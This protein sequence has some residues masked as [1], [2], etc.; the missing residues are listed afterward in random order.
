LHDLIHNRSTTIYGNGLVVRD[1]VHAPDVGSAV[2]QLLTA[3]ATPTI[4][5]VGSG[6]GRSILD[7][8]SICSSVTGRELSVR[9]ERARSFDIEKNVLDISRL[10][11]LIDFS[12]TEP[13]SAIR[14]IWGSMAGGTETVAHRNLRRLGG[15]H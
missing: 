2:L 12:P 5:N 13:E 4:L 9:F 6:R 1:Y 10:R 8:I 7:L 15:I 14:Q 3:P 11:R